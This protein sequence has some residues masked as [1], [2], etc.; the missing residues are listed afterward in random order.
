MVYLSQLCTILVWRKFF[1][2]IHAEQQEVIDGILLDSVKNADDT[3]I[4]ANSPS[5]L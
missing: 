5:F 4:L 3:A 2:V 1:L